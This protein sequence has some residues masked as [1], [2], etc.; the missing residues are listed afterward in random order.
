MVT[1]RRH[2]ALLS[3]RHFTNRQG[4]VRTACQV[5]VDA[6]CWSSPDTREQTGSRLEIA[7]RLQGQARAAS[8]RLG[9]VSGSHPAVAALILGLP[10]GD[11]STYWSTGRKR[12]GRGESQK[13]S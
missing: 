4:T 5:A 10:L 7:P 9:M 2:G 12:A 6:D 13:C 3:D 1:P 8:R 11:W